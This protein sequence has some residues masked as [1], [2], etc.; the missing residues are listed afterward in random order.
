MTR[1][2]WMRGAVLVVMA[3]LA[4]V[5]WIPGEPAASSGDVGGGP[6]VVEPS[7]DGGMR[8]VRFPQFEPENHRRSHPIQKGRSVRFAVREDVEITP[9]SHG[10]WE[11]NQEG[12]VWRLAI[13]APG[14][15]NLNLGFSEF[16]LPKSAQ[17]EMATGDG[18]AVRPF[19]AWDNE[20]HGE[21]WTPTVS[22]ERLELVLRVADSE[23]DEVLLTLQAVNRGFRSPGFVAGLRKIG[24]GSPD[25]RCHIDVVCTAEESGV[26]AV[27]DAYRDQMRSAGVFS[28][29]GTD[30]CS[31]AAL[32]NVRNDRRPYFLTAAHC[33]IDQSNAASLVVFWNHENSSCRQPGSP[34]NGGEGDGPITDFNTGAIFRASHPFSDAALVELDDPFDPTHQV[35]LAGWS[36]TSVPTMGV[37]VHFP[38]TTEKRMSFDFDELQSTGDSAYEVD[39]NGS[40]WQVLDW[41]HGSTEGGSSGS[42]LFDQ[43]G[44][45]VGHLSGGFADCSNNLPDW[46]GK[47]SRAWVGDGTAST[48]L[49]DWLDPDD[50]G[51]SELDGI[52][53]G[54]ILVTIA[55]SEVAEGD[56]GVHPLK[57]KVQ[58]SEPAPEVITLSYETISQ[59][60]L[61]AEDFNAVAGMSFEFQPGEETKEISVG[62]IGDEDPEEQE[63]FVVKLSIVEGDGVV[64]QRSE[65]FGTIRNDDFIAPVIDEPSTRVLIVGQQLET[66]VM[67]SNTP[68]SYSLTNALPGMTLE[69]GVLRWRPLE[70]GS[71]EVLLMVQNPAGTDEKSL[72][73]V[74][75]SDPQLSALDSGGGLAVR[76]GSDWQVAHGGAVSGLTRLESGPLGDKAAASFSLDVSGPDYLGFWWRVS[77]EEDF[78]FLSLRVDG[79]LKQSISGEQAW[80]YQVLFV[81]P[82]DHV[83]SWIY[84]K[85]ASESGGLDRGMLDLVQLSSQGQPFLMETTD[86]FVRAGEP[87]EFQFTTAVPGARFVQK[88]LG[89]G[90]FLTREGT[91]TGTPSPG[92]RTFTLEV[93]QGGRTLSLPASME[94]VASSA[95]GAVVNQ[96]DLLWMVE[97]AGNWQSQGL[98]RD[99]LGLRI[100]G[101]PDDE[102]GSLS[103]WIYGPGQVSFWWRVS[104]EQS[105]D[106]LSFRIDGVDQRVLSG[107]E[108][109]ENVVV[110]IPMGWHKLGW[111]YFRDEADSGGINAG[112]LDQ[113]SFQGYTG[114]AQ[115]EG[116]GLLG[117]VARDGDGDGLSQ[118]FEYATG[119]SPSSVDQFSGPAWVDGRLEWRIKRA[120]GRAV[121]MDAEGSGDLVEWNRTERLILQ[122][123]EDFFH[124][125]DASPEGA[126]ERFLRLQVYPE[127]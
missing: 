82:G 43:H 9:Q 106:G 37:G 57:F 1:R 7:T 124:V 76:P 105:Y 90:L 52:E 35:F 110:E 4:I 91:V 69:E 6:P 126:R 112:W 48:R 84:E 3:L 26:G 94:A 125:R 10:Q 62:I 39:P 27:V 17:L 111:V 93:E 66:E 31:G 16:W 114:W 8:V 32:N 77:S 118:L 115:A 119:G 113:I 122:D 60:A 89:G 33:G 86:H 58:L 29:E 83:I 19:T 96:P 18:L 67:V 56:E 108:D 46:Y 65:A 103:T 73:F 100:S 59:S 70:A 25:G 109:W 72:T 85:D 92:R 2:D 117:S 28:L 81:P 55:D 88:P 61:M 11:V 38:A 78:D 41:D 99:G 107:E 47:F 97:G 15:L 80:R 49:R 21:L 20:S 123:D 12:A 68:T 116:L 74:V 98:S 34:S 40:H 53:S 13:E 75:R 42:P 50:T 23:R 95:L 54:G 24:D 127:K 22:G 51:I 102:M 64:F 104:S 101:V 45:V 121:T 87:L 44:R 120:A 5:L 71:F 14:A 79:E 63:S 30:A 36:T